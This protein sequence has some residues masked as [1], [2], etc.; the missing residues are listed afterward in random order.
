MKWL[1]FL[2]LTLLLLLFQHEEASAALT[3]LTDLQLFS[4]GKIIGGE[5]ATASDYP[6]YAASHGDGGRCGASLIAPNLLLGAAHCQGSFIG[7][8]HFGETTSTWK[9]GTQ[10]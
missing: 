3:S 10:A 9:T 1:V 6:W 4:A 7:G 8:A 5:D 2:Q